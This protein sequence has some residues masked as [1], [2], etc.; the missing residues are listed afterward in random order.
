MSYSVSGN[1]KA[2]VIPDGRMA[3]GRVKGVE[4]VY[5]ANGV[6]KPVLGTTW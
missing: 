2:A 6:I 4:E 3:F 5:R 1:D